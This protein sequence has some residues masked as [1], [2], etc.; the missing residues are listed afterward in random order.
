MYEITA[1]SYSST[2]KC[3]VKKCSLARKQ[4]MLVS[5]ILYYK[6]ITLYCRDFVGHTD[7]KVKYII[8]N[9]SLFMTTCA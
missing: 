4:V 9:V 8:Y 1:M 2:H 6:V 7:W 5:R 3:Y